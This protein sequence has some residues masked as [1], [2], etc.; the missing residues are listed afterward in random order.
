MALTISTTFKAARQDAATELEDGFHGTASGGSTTTLTTIDSEIA[1][2]PNDYFNGSEISIVAGTGSKV[3]RNVDDF[4]V[5]GATATFT[6]RAI[7]VAPVSTDEF[8][9]HRLRG[10]G[11]TKEQYD[12][13]INRGIRS[14]A[15]GYQ[16][17]QSSIYFGF[18]S[19]GRTKNRAR[20][21]YPLPG[22]VTFNYLTAMQYLVPGP[23]T[24]W[25]ADNLKTYRAFGDATART[26]VWQGFK[27]G[28][29]G[30]YRYLVVHMHTVGTP[31]GT[32]IADIMADSS[33]VPDGTAISPY[34][35]SQALTGSNLPSEPGYVVFTF[36][37]PV[38]LS[39]N[40]QYHLVLRRSVSVDASNYFRVSEDNEGAYNDGTA[41]IYDAATYTAVS[42]SDLCFAIF[43]ASDK[44]LTLA[45]KLW[46]INRLSTNNIVFRK[47]PTEATPIRIVG[48]APIAEVSA[49]TDTIPIRPEWLTQFV[50]QDLLNPRSGMSTPQENLAATAQAV[51]R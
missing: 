21:E 49:E 38:F 33:G 11:W 17:D 24:L 44:W 46:N 27:V 10:R 26:R 30:L 36:N 23:M 15:D 31:T 47:G 50:V 41:G 18:E 3:S 40:T 35:S 4:A 20:S 22:G 28:T 45:P 8:E 51:T 32:V 29:E 6:F 25:A 1:K 2:R 42:A 48:L 9:V 14:L 34:G 5:S 13:A 19:G 37:P 16:T 39:E 43:I 12:R 7:A